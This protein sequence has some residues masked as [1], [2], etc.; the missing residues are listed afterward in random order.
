M[1]D[2][3]G[4]VAQVRSGGRWSIVAGVILVIAGIL[5]I[6]VPYIPA[7]VATLWVG[8]ALVFAAWPR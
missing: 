6:G 3:V 2:P 7:L 5:A 8:W 4:G 1:A